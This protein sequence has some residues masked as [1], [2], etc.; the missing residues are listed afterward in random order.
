MSNES[1]GKI[2]I[3]LS[4]EGEKKLR[5]SWKKPEIHIKRGWT[6]GSC[7]RKKG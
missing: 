4:K 5:E 7:P 1:M 2:T 3:S 6:Y